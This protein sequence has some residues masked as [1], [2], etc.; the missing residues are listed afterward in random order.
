[1]RPRRAAQVLVPLMCVVLATQAGA[2]T[3]LLGDSNGQVAAW[4]DSALGA[5]N[6]PPGSFQTIS[7]GWF[8][9]LGILADGT[10][11]GWGRDDHGQATP[12]T[13][14][15][16]AI[17]AGGYHSLGLRADGTAAGWGKD[18]Y[19]QATPPT[20]P[21][22]QFTAVAPGFQHSLGLRAD[23]TVAGWGRDDYGQAT[24]PTGPTDQF[25]AIAAGYLHSLGLRA[26]GT[27]AGWGW[28]G[29]GQ[30][31]APTD[32]FTAIAAGGYHNLGV[33]ADGTVVGWGLDEYGQATA[34][35][36]NFVAV[37][38]GGFHSLGLRTDGTLAAWGL[39]EYGQATAPTGSFVA[40]AAGGFHSLALY[41]RTSYE[42]LLVNGQG[43]TDVDS[44]LNRMI[45]V[46]GDATIQTTM[47]TANNPT[48]AVG[49][50]I[51]LE[52][53]GGIQ[54]DGN[55]LGQFEGKARSSVTAVSGPM[56]LGSLAS[57]N[58]FVHDGMLNVGVHNVL[59]LDSDEAIL[60]G[61]TT[62]MGGQLM[63]SAGITLTYTGSIE[64]YGT[65]QNNLTNHGVVNGASLG[66]TLPGVINGDGDFL[67]TVQFT[68]L[69]SPGMSP[70]SVT[71]GD[72]TF[73]NTLEMELG[74][75]IQGTEYDHIDILGTATLGGTLNVVL[76]NGFTPNWGD[77]FDLFDGT[78][79][80]EFDTVNLPVLAGGLSWDWSRLYTEG[81]IGV[82]PL[83]GAV[84]LGVLG[85]ATAGGLLRRWAWSSPAVTP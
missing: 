33:R 11:T 46:A 15:F 69:Y 83:P 85:M 36:G 32:T 50:Q 82:T 61:K 29:Y 58:G 67:G 34:P 21:M 13:E 28:D 48:M 81:E 80:G 41:A 35:T 63:S 4:G 45:T 17:A 39:D 73:A 8:H 37:A 71:L 24:A 65:I 57:P 25:T 62:M 72:P 9:S 10:A 16:T 84:L 14:V 5:T 6:V 79:V 54:G 76:I 77:W 38:A 20:G 74:G 43:V 70:A 2:D 19:G 49:G 40:V 12:P 75:R 51:T 47:Y 31:T 78:L 27:A 53:G 1:M 18:D 59:L 56:I 66:L 44:W 23:G 7:G 55:F 26:D 60:G 22:D 52:P 64:G 42:D 3:G 68:G 30:A